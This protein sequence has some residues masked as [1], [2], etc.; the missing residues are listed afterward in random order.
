MRSSNERAE[1]LPLSIAELLMR[2]SC[3]ASK[4]SATRRSGSHSPNSRWNLRRT[5]SFQSISPCTDT[6]RTPGV[7]DSP[8]CQPSMVRGYTSVE[9]GERNSADARR[10]HDAGRTRYS[11]GRRHTANACLRLG[12]RGRGFACDR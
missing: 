7:G 9:G 5:A 1:L 12:R 8:W 6:L 11:W 3:A 2:S 10:L 4:T